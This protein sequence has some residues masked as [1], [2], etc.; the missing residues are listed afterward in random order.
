M[1]PDISHPNR[2]ASARSRQRI[3]SFIGALGEEGE[4]YLYVLT[5]TINS[6]AHGRGKV[7]KLVPQ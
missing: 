6:V 1:I 3:K 5:N 7:F 4:G 2:A